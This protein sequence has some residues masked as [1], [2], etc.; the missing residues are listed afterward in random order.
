MSNNIKKINFILNYLRGRKWLAA[1]MIGNA[2]S[3][4]SGHESVSRECEFL[5]GEGLLERSKWGKYRLKNEG[6]TLGNG[7]LE[8][9]SKAIIDRIADRI[10]DKVFR[11]TLLR[12][13]E[14]IQT[15]TSSEEEDAAKKPKKLEAREWDPAGDDVVYKRGY[16]DACD[17]WEEYTKGRNATRSRDCR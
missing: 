3:E 7:K 16:N 8:E 11:E 17:N 13:L 2:Y 12:L 9:I 1:T 6:K 5:V 14:D 4:D 10:P 15:A